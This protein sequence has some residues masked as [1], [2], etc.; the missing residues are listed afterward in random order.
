LVLDLSRLDLADIAEA[1]ANQTD[2][3]HHWLINPETGELER[4]IQG[5]GAFRRFNDELQ[6]APRPAA[7]VARLSRYPRHAPRRRMARRQLT[8]R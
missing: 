3:E 8:H 5:R 1:L 4:A 7:G 2:Y 6:G